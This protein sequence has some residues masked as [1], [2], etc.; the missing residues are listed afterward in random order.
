MTKQLAIGVATKFIDENTDCMPNFYIERKFIQ[1]IV[2][3]CA[4]II[5][6]RTGAL[7][8]SLPITWNRKSSGVIVRSVLTNVIQRQITNFFLNSYDASLRN[9]GTLWTNKII[10]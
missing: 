3:L 2:Y 7:C 6:V 1:S 8:R 5:R 9:R 4:I 10:T